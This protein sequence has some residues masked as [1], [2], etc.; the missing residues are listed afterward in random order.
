MAWWQ[1]C[2]SVYDS[3]GN[4]EDELVKASVAYAGSSILKPSDIVNPAVDGVGY[5]GTGNMY[6][7]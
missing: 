7:Y 1:R 5:V 4:A 6:M 3:D 2:N